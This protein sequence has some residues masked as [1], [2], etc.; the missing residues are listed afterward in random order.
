MKKN[1]KIKKDTRSFLEKKADYFVNASVKEKKRWY[2]ENYNFSSKHLCYPL[3]KFLLKLRIRNKKLNF[4]R[5]VLVDILRN[6][7][8]RFFGIY[9]YVALPGEGKTMSMVAHMER[10]R[11]KFGKKVYIATNFNYRYQDR[12]IEHWLDIV[13][14]SKHC[15]KNNLKCIVAIDEIHTTFD[16]SDW[17]AFP[18]ELLAL[19]SFNRKVQMQFICSSQIYDRVPKKIR[20]IANYVVI[21][22]NILGCDRLFQNFYF[23]KSNYDESFTGKRK[24]ADF[25]REFVVDDDFQKLYNTLEQ[26]DKLTEDAKREKE[27]RQEAF[28]LLFGKVTDE[29]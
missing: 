20:D 2:K 22:K 24:K 7:I 4:V 23:E 27:K 15:T 26:V 10:V 5:W 29:D 6:K 12:K 25:L 3:E 8:R 14:T 19:L 11:E 18:P 28:E 21:C 13:E 17:K 1:L 16:S 9:I